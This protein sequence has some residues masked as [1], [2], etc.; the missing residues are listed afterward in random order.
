MEG[1]PWSLMVAMATSIRSAVGTVSSRSRVNTHTDSAGQ[2]GDQIQEAAK[3]SISV[4]N[5]K[6]RSRVE[7]GFF[8]SQ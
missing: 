3:I 8:G 2:T 4:R 1:P 6:Y 7:E 5:Q